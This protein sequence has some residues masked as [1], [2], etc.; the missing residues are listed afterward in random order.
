[1][2]DSVDDEF[3]IEPHWDL[4]RQVSERT[5]PQPMVTCSVGGKVHL[6]NTTSSPSTLHHPTSK[7]HEET[8]QLNIDPDNL[9]STSEK[10]RF[11]QLSKE[12]SDI[13][14]KDL[15]GYN[16]SSGQFVAT[17]NMDPTQPP[18]RRG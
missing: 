9:L 2:P 12:F 4:S 8:P 10:K 16:G 15:P 3:A 18:Q 13:F 7:Y 1:M 11:Q 14:G 5:W 6:V 17:L